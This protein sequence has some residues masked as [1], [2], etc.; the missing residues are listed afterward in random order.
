MLTELS[1]FLGMRE[2]KDSEHL[3][4]IL[5]CLRTKY[6][7]ADEHYKQEEKYRM[8]LQDFA[9]DPKRTKMDLETLRKTDQYLNWISSKQSSLLVL[10]GQNERGI[11]E[12][13]GRCCW[14][15]PAVI[16]FIDESRQNG[17]FLLYHLNLRH[18]NQIDDPTAHDIFTSFAAQLL[19]K[20]PKLLR[21]P[22]EFRHLQSKLQRLDW[23]DDIEEICD[24]LIRIL[25]LLEDGSP[26]EI[27]LDRID[28][29]SG[30]ISEVRLMNALLR[31]VR[32]VNCT[33]KILVVACSTNW[34]ITKETKS[35]NTRGLGEGVFAKLVRN[36]ELQDCY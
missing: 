7:D 17:R 5:K 15:S 26:V 21:D 9:E 3:T 30:F 31:M 12:S 19:T 36:Q 14:L 22:T 4:E 25:N 28:V 35:L 2:T 23:E 33:V 10:S 24:F 18:Q 16:D 27:I 6:Y 29:C 8:Q 32:S 1:R 20:R 11:I 34:D 13:H